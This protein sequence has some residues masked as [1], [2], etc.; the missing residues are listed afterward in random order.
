MKKDIEQQLR[1]AVKKCPFSMYHL[2]LHSDVAESQLSRFVNGQRTL[3]LDAAARIA[4][5]LN[6][7]LVPIQKPAAKPQVESVVEKIP[8]PIEP[9]SP[10]AKPQVEK[11]SQKVEQAIRPPSPPSKPQRRKPQPSPQVDA[12][13]DQVAI[14]QKLNTPACQA[15]A[16]QWFDYLDGKGMQER[17]PKYNAP[18]LQVWWQ[19]MGRKSPEAFVRDVEGSIANGWQNIQD[20]SERKS[21]GSSGQPSFDPDFLR[22]VQICREYSG[23]NDDDRK[24]RQSRLTTLGPDVVRIVRKITSARLTDCND[25]NRKALAEEWMTYKKLQR[26]IPAIMRTIDPAADGGALV[27]FSRLRPQAK[28]SK[29]DF[30]DLLLSLARERL[31]HLHRHDF[32]DSLSASELQELVHDGEGTYFIGAALPNTRKY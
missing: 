27:T 7:Q 26:D 8:Q 11:V 16:Q 32:P 12:S 25:F 2:S 15:A 18:Q 10:A 28:L 6:L 1:E 13:V 17:N 4:A 20:C 31:V 21:A 24:Q 29:Q 5:A 9:P 14:P 23:A 3:R 30:D 19:N 22:A